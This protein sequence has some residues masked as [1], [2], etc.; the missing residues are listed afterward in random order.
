MFNFWDFI[1]ILIFSVVLV[2]LIF[3]RL[4]EKKSEKFEKRNN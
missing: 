3:E 4:K 1:F 2:Y